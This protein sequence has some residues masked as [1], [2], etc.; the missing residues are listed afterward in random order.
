[1]YKTN[2]LLKYN[3]KYLVLKKN[4]FLTK[5]YY[6]IKPSTEICEGTITFLSIRIIL[7]QSELPRPNLCNSVESDLGCTSRIYFDDLTLT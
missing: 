2:V 5:S 3:F 4:G 1:M 7:D 6:C